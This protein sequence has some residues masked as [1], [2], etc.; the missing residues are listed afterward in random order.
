MKHYIYQYRNEVVKTVIVTFI[1]VTLISLISN[2][3]EQLDFGTITL[4]ALLVTR[5][6][7]FLLIV[8]LFVKKQVEVTFFNAL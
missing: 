7:F 6:L 1:V 3:D 8:Y 5:R 2:T 4:K